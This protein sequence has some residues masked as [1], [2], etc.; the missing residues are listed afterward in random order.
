MEERFSRTAMLLGL[1][2]VE[3]LLKSHVAIV[4][5]GG[6]GSYAAEAIARAGVGE[7]TL[8]DCDMVSVTNINRQLCALTSTVGLPKA[9][10]T[11]RRVADI[12]PNAVVHSLA[13]FYEPETRE[14]FFSTRF[15]Y[16]IDAIDTVSAKT[17]LICTAI[18]RGIPIVS[19]LGTGNKLYPERLQFADIYKTSVCPLARAMRRELRK[20]GVAAHTV[21]YSTE[22]PRGATENENGRNYPG[23]IS[24][25]PGCAGLML[26]GFVIRSL[27]G[28]PD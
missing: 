8:V 26:A 4:G 13:L 16:I 22:E 25:V 21:L 5:L 11:A 9:E 10:V 27:S 20:R 3:D 1:D 14:M 15:D 2:A 28:L 19:A 24:W 18:A 12:N 7:L 6:V 23:S 17:D